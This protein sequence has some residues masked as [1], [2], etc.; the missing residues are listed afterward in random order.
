MTITNTQAS[1]TT[2]VSMRDS[3]SADFMKII[4]SDT[5]AEI[6]TQSTPSIIQE[7]LSTTTENVDTAISTVMTSTLT[8]ATTGM[9]Y[10]DSYSCLKLF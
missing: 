4:T 10:V 5:S 7:V 6:V 3:T 8:Q 2:F 1:G 9:V